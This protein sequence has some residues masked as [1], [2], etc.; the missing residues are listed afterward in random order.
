[1]DPVIQCFVSGDHTLREGEELLGTAKTASGQ[2]TCS[3]PGQQ[4]VPRRRMAKGSGR[5][6]PS[7]NSRFRD[8]GD[9]QRGLFQ[10]YQRAKGARLLTHSE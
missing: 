10:S 5:K 1:M 9:A 2:Q 8:A 6:D 7:G 4:P 3:W